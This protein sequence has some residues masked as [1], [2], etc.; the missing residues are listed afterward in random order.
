VDL[1]DDRG[2]IAA[3]LEAEAAQP[4][5]ANF[6]NRM[7][8]IHLSMGDREKAVACFRRAIEKN[9]LLLYPYE[10]MGTELAA[11]GKI[12]ETRELYKKGLKAAEQVA[13]TSP[14]ADVRAEADFYRF[15]FRWNLDELEAYRK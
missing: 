7:G 11:L 5:E 3:L 6:P 13:S 12:E 4:S 8:L 10:N 1:G 2:A 9:P 14:R 15:L